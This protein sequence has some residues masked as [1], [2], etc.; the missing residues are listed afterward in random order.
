VL[1][2]DDDSTIATLR[3]VVARAQPG[4]RVEIIQSLADHNPEPQVTTALD[5]LLLLNGGGHKHT[6]PQVAGLLE[7]SGLRF[8]GVRPTGTFLSFVEAVVPDPAP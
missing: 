7:R 3:N 6:L 1:E 2:W 5:L 4:A 8:A